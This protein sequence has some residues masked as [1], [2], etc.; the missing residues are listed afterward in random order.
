MGDRYVSY[1]KMSFLFNLLDID[2]FWDNHQTVD[3]IETYKLKP[4][5]HTN[6]ICCNSVNSKGSRKLCL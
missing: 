5:S 3:E 1:I 2:S 6:Q 4:N